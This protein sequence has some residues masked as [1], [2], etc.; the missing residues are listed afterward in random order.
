MIMMIKN[1]EFSHLYNSLGSASKVR[2]ESRIMID[3]VEI[4]RREITKKQG[5]H[6]NGMRGLDRR[7]RVLLKYSFVEV[8]GG[9]KGQKIL[10]ATPG[11]HQKKRGKATKKLFL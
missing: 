5:K 3:V 8:W 7:K 1:L 11:K 6:V 10:I 9:F 4:I 2:H